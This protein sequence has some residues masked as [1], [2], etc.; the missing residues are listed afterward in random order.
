[1]SHLDQRPNTHDASVVSPLW[2][3]EAHLATLSTPHRMFPIERILL[4]VDLTPY[5]ERAIPYALALA[6]ATN[7]SMTLAHVADPDSAHP[8]SVSLP[9]AT[10]Y[11]TTIRE[12]LLV[13][14][15]QHVAMRIIRGSDV[16]E[17]LDELAKLTQ[18]AVVT[19]AT[20]ARQGIEQPLLGKVGD[21]LIRRGSASV[22]LVPPKLEP[23]Q[24]PPTF[25]R[26]LAP[27]DG[28][29]LAERALEPVLTLA[30]QARAPM[31]IVLFFVGETREGRDDGLRYVTAA[32]AALLEEDLSG[33]A[34]IFA[35]SVIGSPPGAIVGAA[36]HGIATA[37][38]A[39][40]SFDLVVM[41][42]HGRGGLQR[43][44]Y[45][46]VAAYV[47]PRLTIPALL[48]PPKAGYAA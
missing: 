9:A 30:R 4:P 33:V 24:S 35:A 46:S 48:V 42:T 45:G 11:L 15:E 14:A 26:I 27:L 16:A 36:T 7:A 32:R 29:L 31:D 20:H 12:T 13:D 5:S 6:Q 47:I 39:N 10:A 25:R 43:W 28:S 34:R 23:Q 2:T 19:L 3:A 1:M 44:L 37:T 21:S 17:A 22:L 18:S 38:H 40:G 41:A 8:R